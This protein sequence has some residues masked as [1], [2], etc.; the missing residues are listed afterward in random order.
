MNIQLQELYLKKIN[1]INNLDFEGEDL[2]GPLLMHCWEKEYI[3]SEYKILFVGR[4]SNG[5]LGHLTTNIHESLYRYCDFELCNNGNYTRFWQYIYD[6]KNILMPQTIGKRNF[7]WTNLSKF[8]TENGKAISKKN[9]ELLVN[10]FNV[11]Q[12][13]IEI[14]KPDII[15]FFTGN[16]WDHKIKNHFIDEIS[17]EIVNKK[18]DKSELVQVKSRLLPIHTYRVNHPIT[19]SIEKKWNLMEEIIEQIRKKQL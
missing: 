1:G 2:D 8:S 9:Y 12:R 5:W 3:S 14:L 17:F 19:L 4:E 18:I 11:F 6:F 13:E 16:K 7:M 10:K 15:I